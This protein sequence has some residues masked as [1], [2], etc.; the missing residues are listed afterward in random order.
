[1]SSLGTQY[2]KVNGSWSSGVQSRM[3]WMP[4]K[5]NLRQPRWLNPWK[6]ELSWDLTAAFT[7]LMGDTE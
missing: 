2:K 6:R 3:E 1:M 4:Y 5:E 7:C